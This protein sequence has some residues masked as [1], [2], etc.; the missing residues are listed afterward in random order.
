SCV[1]P[2]PTLSDDLLDRI[3]ASV[4]T[5]AR[6][7]QVRGLLN[8]QL[9]VRDEVPYVLEANPRASRT[10]PFVGKATGLPL[11]KI[12]AR[13]M[14]GATLPDLRAEGLL[15]HDSGAYR[16]LPHVAVKAAVLPFARFP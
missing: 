5:I 11:A 13:V 2:P 4:V 12:A 6:A 9:A 3:E 8:V 14:A 16:R 15:R 7:L 1:I 10:V